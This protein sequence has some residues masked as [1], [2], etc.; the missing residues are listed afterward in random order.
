MNAAANVKR[1][2]D[3]AMARGSYRAFRQFHEAVIGQTVT[4]D[5]YTFA[6]QVMDAAKNSGGSI[7]QRIIYARAIARYGADNPLER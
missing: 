7:M 5:E 3:S 6:L 4:G 1:Y 2:I